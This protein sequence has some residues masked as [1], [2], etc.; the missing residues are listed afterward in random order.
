MQRMKHLLTRDDGLMALEGAM[1]LPF[2][3]LLLFVLVEGVNTIQSYAT[4]AEASRSAARHIVLSQET[5]TAASLVESLIKELPPEAV[6]TVVS[7]DEASDKVT[8]EVLYDYQSIFTTSP[9]PE[10]EYDGV[11]TLRASTTM[12]MP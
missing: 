9:L 10:E 6:S 3:A 7:V 5:A 12:P 8:V 2:M 4:I 11:F 1:M